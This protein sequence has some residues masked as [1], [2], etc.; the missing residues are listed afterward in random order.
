M[1]EDMRP[2]RIAFLLLPDFTHLAFSCAV[3]PLRIAN[4]IAGREVYSWRLLAEDGTSAT[5]S[6]GAVTLVDGDLGSLG[7]DEEAFVVSGLRVPDHVTPGLLHPLRRAKAHG[8]RIG[9]ICSGAYVLARAGFLNG[10]KATIHWA[11]HGLMREKFPDVDL[12]SSVFVSDPLHPTA[13]GGTAAADMMLHRIAQDHG[14]DVAMEV[15]NQMLYSAIRDSGASQRISL[16]ARHG[17]RSTHLVRAIALIEDSVETPLSPPEIAEELGISVRQLE[18]LFGKYLN[19][20]PKRYIT[21]TRLQRC[22]PRC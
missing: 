3:E 9:A 5:C 13:S 10:R 14:R 21:E 7:R 1:T 12:Q 20:S 16:Q 4:F 19:T 2:R 17:F 11:W 6:N 22:S 18:R 8:T 15:S